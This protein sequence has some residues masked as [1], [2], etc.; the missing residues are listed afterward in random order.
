MVKLVC[1]AIAGGELGDPICLQCQVGQYLPDWHP[2]EDYRQAYYARR[3]LGGGVTLTLSHEID[4]AMAMLGPVAT[5]Q[6]R[7]RRR[8]NLEIDVDA[9]S[10]LTLQHLSGAV[11]QIHLDYC[12]RLLSRC[13]TVVCS[14]GLGA[15]R[16]CIAFRAGA[17]ARRTTSRG[18]FG[19]T[20]RTSGTTHMW[21]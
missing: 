13:G 12:Q 16:H 3:D 15:I 20:S 18:N 11:S 7:S 14:R 1:E 19:T 5:V 21:T 8:R 17:K 10:D 6:G 4:M 2:Q 9:V